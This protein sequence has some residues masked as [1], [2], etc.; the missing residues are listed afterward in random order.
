M[1]EV[2]GLWRFIPPKSQANLEKIAEIIGASRGAAVA[3]KMCTEALDEYCPPGEQIKVIAA[4]A[5]KVTR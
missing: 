5:I 2:E 3:L 1:S 4:L